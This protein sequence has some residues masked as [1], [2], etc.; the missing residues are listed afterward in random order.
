MDKPIPDGYLEIERMDPLDMSGGTEMVVYSFANIRDWH[1]ESYGIV[2][3]SE[4]KRNIIPWD[5]VIEVIVH[6][7]SPA[8]ADALGKYSK[9]MQRELHEVGKITSGPRRDPE[10]FV[11]NRNPAP[12]HPLWG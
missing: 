8:I 3:N 11:Q 2:I 10:T 6:K 12:H 5:L 1:P 7:N 9:Y 4:E